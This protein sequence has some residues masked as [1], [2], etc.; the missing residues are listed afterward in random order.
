MLALLLGLPAPPVQAQNYRARVQLPG[1][2]LPVA[3]DTLTVNTEFDAPYSKVF[4]AVQ[5]ALFELKI[6]VSMADSA[7]GLVLNGEITAIR[8]WAGA[9]PSAYINCGSSMTGLNA[10]NYRL[11]L[12]VGALLTPL[13]AE[14]TRLGVALVASG[15]DITGDSKDPVNCGSHGTFEHKVAE[16]VKAKLRAS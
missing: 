3:L 13:T 16:L 12:A 5:Q 14:R 9:Q 8:R 11:T 2:R 15:R 7:R 6:P 4:L 10:D 1:F